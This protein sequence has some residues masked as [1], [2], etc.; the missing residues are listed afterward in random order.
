MWRVHGRGGTENRRTFFWVK[1]ADMEAHRAW[2]PDL[3]RVRW[4]CPPQ[5][6][7]CPGIRRALPPVPRS[8]S[9]NAGM[10]LFGRQAPICNRHLFDGQRAKMRD[11][12]LQAR[13]ENGCVMCGTPIAALEG[14]G[15]HRKSRAAHPNERRKRCRQGATGAPEAPPAAQPGSAGR[16]APGG[17]LPPPHGG[18]CRPNIAQSPAPLPRAAPPPK[19][20]IQLITSR[21]C[22][23]I[24]KQVRIS[25]AMIRWPALLISWPSDFKAYWASR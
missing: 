20:P 13:Q 22:D 12:K 5:S 11:C 25:K 17:A 8:S 2:G 19:S 24:S 4:R 21:R 18:R 1:P 16:G 6:R 9:L 14:G 10:L 7:Q 23:V 15:A 3:R